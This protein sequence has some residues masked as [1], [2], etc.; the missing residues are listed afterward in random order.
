[1]HTSFERFAAFR[2]INREEAFGWRV[3]RPAKRIAERLEEA[4]C[5]CASGVNSSSG[6][7]RGMARNASSSTEH[8]CNPRNLYLT[9]E[10]Y[11]IRPL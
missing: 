5:T 1:M 9:H 7:S 6:S 10:F 11:A 3:S 8:E 2:S 4:A